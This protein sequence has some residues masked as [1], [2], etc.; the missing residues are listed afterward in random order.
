M[1]A[2]ENYLLHAGIF[3]KRIVEAVHVTSL[4]RDESTAFLFLR[5][6]FG[7]YGSQLTLIFV[8]INMYICLDFIKGV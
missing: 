6:K 7:Q 1:R 2:F 4:Y 8:K 3:K 5:L